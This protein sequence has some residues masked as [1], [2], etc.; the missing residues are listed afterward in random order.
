MNNVFFNKTMEN[1]RARQ[2]IDIISNDP[3]R[4]N[5]YTA[6]STYKSYIEITED[7][8]SVERNKA[9]I[10]LKQIFPNVQLLFT[11]AYSLCLG[12]EDCDNVYGKIQESTIINQNGEETRAIDEFDLSAYSSE[13]PIFRQNK[14]TKI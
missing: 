1:V 2:N 6:K 10:N 7:I 14:D 9:T 5:R 4:L 13:H 8:V 3:K 11:D 12:I